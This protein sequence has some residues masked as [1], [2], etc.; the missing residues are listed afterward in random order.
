[1]LSQGIPRY[2]LVDPDGFLCEPEYDVGVVLR[3]FSRELLRLGGPRRARELHA[4]LTR[5]AAEST[6]TDVERV[7]QWA[8][9]ERVTTGLYLRWFD[10][11]D[12]SQSFLDA[13]ELLLD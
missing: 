12:T 4:R 9:V 5:Q 11:P 1:M 6:G 7:R 8:F 13:A 2:K 3:D 10:D